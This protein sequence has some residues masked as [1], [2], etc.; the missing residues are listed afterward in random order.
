MNSCLIRVGGMSQQIGI[1]DASEIILRFFE[2]PK[3]L[4]VDLLAT[5]SWCHGQSPF[6]VGANN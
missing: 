5:H 2:S 3:G 6:V 1:V 4:L